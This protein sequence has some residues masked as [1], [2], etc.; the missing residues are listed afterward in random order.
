M[1]FFGWIPDDDMKTQRIVGITV[2]FVLVCLAILAGGCT[3][4][5]DTATSPVGSY[6]SPSPAAVQKVEVYHFHATRQ[7][8]SCIALGD[9]AEATVTTFFAPELAS[10]KLVFGHINM[11]LP[12]NRALVEQ[13]GPTG[14][15]LWIGVY[16][17][18]GFHKEENLNVWYR[19][20]NKEEYMAYL[21]DVID[22]RLA[23]DYS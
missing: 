3:A 17:E 20:G 10:G 1:Q 13:Y 22:R 19:L 6:P 7:C 2:L 15:S 11:D 12:G 5:A 16:D 18:N 23:G 9:Y 4:P 8:D 21:K 14:S